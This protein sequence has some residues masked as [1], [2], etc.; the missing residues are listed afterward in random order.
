MDISLISF[1]G[2][3]PGESQ[4]E[5]FVANFKEVSAADEM[6]F[7]AFWAG[8]VPLG[9][10]V[11]HP[12]LLASA[13]AART[14][15][16]KI[17]TAVHLPNLRAPG[18]QFSTDVP[19]GASTINRNEGAAPRYRYAFEHMLPADP[20]QT[21]EQI[22]MIDQVSDGRFIYG[23]GPDTVGDE[24]RQ[25]QFFEWLEVMRKVWTEEEFSGF[26]GEF[27]NYPP[28]PSGARIMPKP[29]QKPYPPILSTVDSQQGFE[30]MGRMGVRIAIG[31]GSSHNQRGDSILKEDVKRYRQA[32][33]DAGH[34]GNAG[35]SIRIPTHV[36]ATKEEVTRN[37]EAVEKARRER[38]AARGITD[39]G[40]SEEG[41]NNML[42]TPEEVVERIHQL[43][44]DFGADEL[45]CE[46]HLG[47]VLNREGV[48]QS[49]RLLS[50]K[51]MPKV[52]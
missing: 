49:M 9:G 48:L 50:D 14:R 17:G 51:V 6:G 46:M 34:P 28:L 32:W 24:G 16:I 40:N 3:K 8:G 7:D 25:N 52:K 33:R 4:G 12:L 47:G 43:Q 20:I 38:Y 39:R 26:Q 30:P 11:S 5:G 35:V 42:G 18:E 21:A 13:I 37:I 31:G 1:W 36:A 44:E 10:M 29:V 23:A 41:S 15:H 19:E 27:Y 2:A 45:M 22:A